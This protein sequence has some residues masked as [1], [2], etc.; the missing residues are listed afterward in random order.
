MGIDC[1]GICPID[2]TD[3]C[4]NGV[5][6]PDETGIDC[7]GFCGDCPPVLGPCE[8][9]VLD[10]GEI[11]ID[12]GGPCPD[13]VDPKCSN[14]I[15]DAGEIG[16][17]CGGSC[18]DCPPEFF[19]NNGIKDA[20]EEGSIVGVRALIAHQHFALMALKMQGKSVLIVGEIVNKAVAQMV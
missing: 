18:E 17:D 2:C 10:K 1:G 14:G 7:G 6:D 4:D 11:S 8:N 16:I 15:L 9:G 5:Q 19:C 12:C 3:L 20:T 13:C